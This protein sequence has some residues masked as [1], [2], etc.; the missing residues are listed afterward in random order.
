MGGKDGRVD[1]GGAEDRAAL[2]LFC[3]LQESYPALCAT[4]NA[5]IEVVQVFSM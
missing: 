1:R 2:V 5:M 4:T 3:S